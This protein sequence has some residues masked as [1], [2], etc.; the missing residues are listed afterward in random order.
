M[1]TESYQTKDSRINQAKAQFGQWRLFALIGF[2][3]A[4]ITGCPVH[5]KVQSELY[6]GSNET[7][8]L[9]LLHGLPETATVKIP[10]G[11]STLIKEIVLLRGY[12]ISTKR[13]SRRIEFEE[14]SPII[15]NLIEWEQRNRSRD[16][17][18]L[19]F[20]VDSKLKVLVGQYSNAGDFIV[21]SPQP[22]GFPF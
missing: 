2:G 16:Q 3:I 18:G 12:T 22:Q 14:R 9:T 20:L 19:A 17:S 10:P 7:L 11:E 1:S 8:I 21:A 13:A 6:N 15:T 4:L 5:T